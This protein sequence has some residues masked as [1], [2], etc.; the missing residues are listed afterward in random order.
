[1]WASISRRHEVKKSRRCQRRPCEAA[2]RYEAACKE[3]CETAVRQL[4]C[5]L[6]V[7]LQGRAGERSAG[8][9]SGL[10]FAPVDKGVWPLAQDE[11]KRVQIVV[12]PRIRG[13]A[14]ATSL[15]ACAAEDM[16]RNGSLTPESGTPTRRRGAPFSGRDGY[17]SRQSSR[18]GRCRLLAPLRVGVVFRSA[19]RIPR[20]ASAAKREAMREAA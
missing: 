2:R 3:A 9:T 15:I 8:S 4:F 12:I 5:I 11:A 7:C 18:R 13:R 20:V 16:F 14:V 19:R 10:R 17:A 6:H 1:M